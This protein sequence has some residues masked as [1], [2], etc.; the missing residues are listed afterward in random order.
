MLLVALAAFVVAV[1]AAGLVIVCWLC[2]SYHF[3]LVL[4]ADTF[5]V[6]VNDTVRIVEFVCLLLLLLES[7]MT[8]VCCRLFVVC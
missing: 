6:R 7:R 3:A 2:Y 4:D 1:A 5:S 8:V